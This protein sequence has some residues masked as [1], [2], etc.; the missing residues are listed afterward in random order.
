MKTALMTFRIQLLLAILLTAVTAFAQPEHRVGISRPDLVG[1]YQPFTADEAFNTLLEELRRQG[2]TIEFVVIDATGVDFEDAAELGKEKG[3]DFLMWGTLRFKNQTP[4]VRAF[5][6]RPAEKTVSAE[7][8]I[9]VYCIE[10]EEF[11]LRQ[12]TW[13]SADTWSSKNREAL[14]HQE[15]AQECLSRAA[16][17]LASAVKLRAENGWFERR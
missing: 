10:K 16:A 11:M 15:L 14:S 5:E 3:L 6:D 2:P 9:K 1:P 8:D 7:V 12:P 13:V 4:T 17:A